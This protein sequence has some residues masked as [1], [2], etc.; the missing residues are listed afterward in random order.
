M[1]GFS[2]ALAAALLL[3]GLA[4]PANAQSDTSATE[5]F[6]FFERGEIGPVEIT[7]IGVVRDQRCADARFCYRPE[8]MRISVILHDGIRMQEVVLRLGE[9]S[10]IPGGFLTLID[11]GT[12]PRARGAL[13][14]SEYRLA[15]RYEAAR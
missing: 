14:L 6:A 2:R 11:P 13:R 12:R 15:I 4:V 7:P 10:A 5:T 9:R 3:S 1:T 8:D